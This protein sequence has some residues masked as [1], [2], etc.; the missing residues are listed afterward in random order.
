MLPACAA[1]ASSAPQLNAIPRKTC[2]HQDR[3]DDALI[4]V[5][6]TARLFGAR[7][8]AWLLGFLVAAAGLAAAAVA[9]AGLDGAALLAALAG[10]LG[11]ASH[12]ARQLGRLDIHDG[13][14]CLH[15]FRS[16]REAGLILTAGLLA[17]AIL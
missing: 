12:L 8:R 11:F 1:Q 6:S 10:V 13:T 5:K 17:A 9:A 7:T 14:L 3:E 4:G 15:L 2:G 16:N